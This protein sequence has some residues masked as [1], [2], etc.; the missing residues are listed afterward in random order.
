[1][2]DRGIKKFAPFKSLNNQDK[3]IKSVVDEKNKTN[4]PELSE[5]QKEEIYYK[6]T[7]LM[8]KDTLVR[9]TYFKDGAISNKRGIC[10][11]KM[12]FVEINKELI[13]AEDI[14]DIDLIGD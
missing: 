4:K 14:L 7:T 3:Y 1:M 2:S 12:P 9:V 10:H 13:K 11:L 5:D 8:S 6:L